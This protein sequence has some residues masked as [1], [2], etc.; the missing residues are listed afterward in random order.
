MRLE[1]NKRLLKKKVIKTL[2]NEYFI[3]ATSS[4]YTSNRLGVALLGGNDSKF[5]YIK[6]NSENRIISL[7]DK[8]NKKRLDR[9]LKVC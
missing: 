7:I 8:N 5:H 9:V 6:E 3:Y 4:I 1:K 2:I